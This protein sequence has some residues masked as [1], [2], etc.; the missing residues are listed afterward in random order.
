MAAKYG[1]RKALE[2]ELEGIV[3]DIEIQQAL[4]RPLPMVQ[5]HQVS[6]TEGAVVMSNGLSNET[7]SFFAE[8]TDIERAVENIDPDYERRVTMRLKR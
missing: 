6:G 4:L 2:L 5:W 8:D 3:L 1:T 7:T